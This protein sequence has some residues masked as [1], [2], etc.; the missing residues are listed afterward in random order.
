MDPEGMYV[1]QNLQNVEYFSDACQDYLYQL[2]RRRHYAL[3]HCVETYL[4]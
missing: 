3:P 1:L 4:V 2:S